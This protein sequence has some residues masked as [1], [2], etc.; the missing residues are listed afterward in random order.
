MDAGKYLAPEKEG[1]A[2]VAILEGT[3]SVTLELVRAGRNLVSSGKARELLIVVQ[4]GAEQ[5]R[6]SE[7]TIHARYLVDQLE[8]MGLRRDQFK[9]LRVPSEHPITLTEARIVVQ[10][11]SLSGV[12]SAILV[13]EGFKTRRSYWVYKQAGMKVGID[14]IPHPYYYRYSRDGWWTESTGV[15]AFS[16]HV[17]KYLYYVIRGYLPLKSLVTI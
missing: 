4:Q 16:L 15:Y 17:F 10:N 12:K 2:E 8:G 14:V 9:I 7:L 6:T 11:M 3:G 13:S 1:R 5:E